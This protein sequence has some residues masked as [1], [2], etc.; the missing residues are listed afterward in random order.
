L[1]NLAVSAIEEET[2]TFAPE[3]QFREAVTRRFIEVRTQLAAIVDDA[4][5]HHVGSTAVPDSLTKGDL[6]IQIRVARARFASARAQLQ[7]LY[8][9]NTGGFSDDDAISF[10]DCSGE[11]S[12]GIHLTV[13]G[14]VS[15]VQMKFRD[16]LLASESLRK[17]YDNLK[18]RFEGGSMEGYRTAKADFVSRVLAGGR[19]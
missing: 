3:R 17:D 7:R 1:D 16:L 4:E 2:V 9:V 8:A 15:D 11:P 13:I 12:V 10:E 6:D 19:F 14:S 5:I 18:R